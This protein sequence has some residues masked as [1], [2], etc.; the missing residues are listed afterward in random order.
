MPQEQRQLT[1]Q[2]AFSCVLVTLGRAAMNAGAGE[3]LCPSVLGSV[4]LCWLGWTAGGPGGCVGLAG[5]AR[6]P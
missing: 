3:R 6:G 1:R 2:L 4:M 5:M